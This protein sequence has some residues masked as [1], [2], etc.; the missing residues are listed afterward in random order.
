MKSK[1]N[2]VFMNKKCEERLG[3]L[4]CLCWGVLNGKISPESMPKNLFSKKIVPHS[5]PLAT[6]ETTLSDK[7]A[8]SR[9][10]LI[11]PPF[12]YKFDYFV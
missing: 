9:F 6:L 11:H 1:L 5:H 4:K 3:A 12:A 2:Q 7:K 8:V 10:P